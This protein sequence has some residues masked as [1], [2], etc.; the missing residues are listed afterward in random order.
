MAQLDTDFEDGDIL[1]AGTTTST[2]NVNGIT[3]K[4]NTKIVLGGA[5]LTATTYDTNTNETELLSVVVPAQTFNYGAFVM[6][7]T[8]LNADNTE[9][10]SGTFRIKTGPDGSETTRMTIIP[11]LDATTVD[12]HNSMHYF[13][14]AA[15]YSS[16]V[17]IILTG[18]LSDATGARQVTGVSLVVFGY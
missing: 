17:S 12:S 11:T 14:V 7:G 6:V 1:F 3:A 4:V 5:D 9:S 18:Q 13:D 16:E 8:R 15:S 10:V 2:S